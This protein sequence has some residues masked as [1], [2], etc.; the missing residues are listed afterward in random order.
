MN[1]RYDDT[2]HATD[3]T[4]QLSLPLCGDGMIPAWAPEWTDDPINCIW[5]KS[6][7]E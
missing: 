3:G 4:D 5:C 7:L 2:V 1:I 6:I